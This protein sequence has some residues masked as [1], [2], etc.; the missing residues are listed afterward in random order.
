MLQ[1][2]CNV[3]SLT[4]AQAEVRLSWARRCALV[5]HVNAT[6]DAFDTGVPSSN[7]AG[8]L[9]DYLED[10]TG[11]NF[12]GLNS[13]V[14]EGDGY[15][16]NGTV[17]NKLYNTGATA[18]YNDANGF[19]RWE[20]AANRKKIR[21][22]YPTYGSQEDINSGSNVQLFPHPTNTTDC[23]LYLNQAGTVPAAGYNYYVNGFCES[24]CY[25]PEQRVLFPDGYSKIVD[26]VKAMKPSVITL[27]PDS[28]LDDIRLQ[29]QATYSYTAEF[30]D[31]THPIVELTMA[32]GGRL[33]VTTEHPL[34]NGE[35]RLV[36]AQTI[37][38]GD[39]LIKVDGSRD[40]VIGVKRTEHFGKVYNLRPNTD[41]RVSNLLI[42]EDYI[43]GSSVYQND[44]I[45]YIN[46]IILHK[47][48]PST[49]IP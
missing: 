25:T 20:R 40:P 5:L 29:T 47:S 21:P 18:Q 22:Y 41:D 24:S 44:E 43:V 19:K 17:T 3:D 10:D 37:K 26:A 35:G 12:F 11:S 4:P 38:V 32:S 23:N 13:Y 15:E 46:R 27:A 36:Q 33:R 31:S 48:M 8:N 45:G 30:R 6:I 9:I 28:S 49:L 42:A 7:G 14:G 2:R 16:I 1:Q 39:S 34:V